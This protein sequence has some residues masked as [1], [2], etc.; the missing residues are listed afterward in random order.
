M[1]NPHK[2]QAYG[3]WAAPRE[4]EALLI[5]PDPAAV[6]RL[7]RDNFVRL[8]AGENVRFCGAPLPEIRAAARAFLGHD[9][10]HPLIATGHQSELHHP[11]VWIKNAVICAAAQACGGAALHVAVDTDGP[12]HLKLKWPGFSAP[13]TDDPRLASAAWTGLLDPPAPAHIEALIDAARLAVAGELASPLLGDFLGSCRSFLVDQRDALAPLDLPAMLANAQHAVDWELG[14]RYSALMLSGLLRSESWAVF[15][16]EIISSGAAFAAAYNRALADYRREAAIDSPDRPMPDLAVTRQRVELPFW[17]DDLVT[18]RRHRAEAVGDMARLVTPGGAE[19]DLNGLPIAGRPAALLEW[20][21]E[22]ELRLAPRALSLTLF[23]RL[24]VCDL[25]V[26]GIGGGH[27]DQVT[28]RLIRDYFRIEPPG[29]A[30]ATATLYHPLSAGRDRICMPCLKH[31]GHELAHRVLGEGKKHWLARLASTP[32]PRQ[33]RAIFEQMH[34]ARREA[35]ETDAAYT[36][37]RKRMGE[38]GQQLQE[39]AE[40]FDRELFY[41]IQPRQRLEAMIAR[42]NDG[43]GGMR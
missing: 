2:Q 10:D 43:F 41:A 27:Y 18:G 42:V 28:D 40:L 1:E 35:L 30:V 31:E 5:W 13:I 38:A 33:R 7:A 39:E 12:K 23:L 16:C 19:L 34:V 8:S 4:D 9:A 24:C 15:A 6:A 14:L 17:L 26:H 11:G 20:L 25:F 37:W 21:R 3:Q 22:H 32:E 29:F 36:G